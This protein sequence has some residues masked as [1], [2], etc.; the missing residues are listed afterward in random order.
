MNKRLLVA[1][2][3]ALAVTLGT[4][5]V[6][7]AETETKKVTKAVAMKCEAKEDDDEKDEAKS[8]A[9]SAK[10]SE[11][12][13][14]DDEKD[15]AKS[16]AKSAKKSE[17]KEEDD[18][19][20]EAKEKKS[21]IVPKAV[22][23]TVKKLLG[24][25]KLLSLAPEEDGNYELDYKVNG[26]H[27]AAIISK[28]GKIQEEEVTVEPSTLPKAVIEAV[29]KLY[30]KGKITVAEKSTTKDGT[31]YELQVSVVK[32]ITVSPKGKVQ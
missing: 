6:R 12:K 18:E 24:K 20:D 5:Q 31:V 19:K 17:A 2:M 23:A 25:G 30:P 7:G 16:D 28:D 1:G 26:V 11:A 29:K 13:E 21:A 15:E 10:K 27:Q 8:D 3:V 22:Q 4:L 32:S 9:K 14:E